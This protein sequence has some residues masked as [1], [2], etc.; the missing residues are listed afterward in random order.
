MALVTS[1]T[2]SVNIP[3]ETE[4][5]IIRKLSHKQLREAARKRQSEGISFM[6]ELGGELIRAMRDA[7]TA[8]VKRL[9]DA[10]EADITNY[11]RDFLLREG[12]VSWSYPVK[13]LVDVGV[14]GLDQLDEPTAKFLAEQIFEFSR[15]ETKDEAKNASAASTNS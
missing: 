5:A 12:V 7:D 9:Q 4:N 10:Q 13:P 11:D 3:N 6:K 15:P 8:T 2:K 1:I 14:S